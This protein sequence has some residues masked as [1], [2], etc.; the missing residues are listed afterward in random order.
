MQ[1]T[2]P[3]AAI[4]AAVIA[5]LSSSLVAIV[6]AVTG[7][8]ERTGDRK[9]ATMLNALEHLTGGSQKRS[10]GIA[11][12]EGMWYDS[13]PFARAILP[14]LVSQAVY[15]LLETKSG[16]QRHQFLNWVRIMRLILR[17][18]PKAEYHDLYCELAEALGQR[19]DEAAMP[20]VGIEIAPP[21]SR[22]WLRKVCEHASLGEP[23]EPGTFA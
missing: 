16:N 18:S 11:L 21:T 10:V 2:A 19:S 12:I 7:F 20:S 9:R 4:Y 6:L 17:V 1:L 14:A 8:I 5:A 3:S 15:L 23:P 22:R 13:Q